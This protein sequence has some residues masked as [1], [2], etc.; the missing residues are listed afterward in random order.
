MPD[1]SSTDIREAFKNGKSASSL[2]PEPVER[3]I[4]DN[5][6]YK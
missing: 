6:L 4:K 2:V 1:I 3:Y 5:G